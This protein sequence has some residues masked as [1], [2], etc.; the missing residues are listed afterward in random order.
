MGLPLLL[1]TGLAS[2][3]FPPPTAPQAQVQP[4]PMSYPVSPLRIC[5]PGCGSEHSQAVRTVSAG[6]NPP[7]HLCAFPCNVNQ[8]AWLQLPA[9]GTTLY[10]SETHPVWFHRLLDGKGKELL[11][12][13]KSTKWKGNLCLQAEQLRLMKHSMQKPLPVFLKV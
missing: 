8:P 4:C 12:A 10:P 7:S 6:I 2:G 5:P 11:A 9:W 13:S 3:S 1:G